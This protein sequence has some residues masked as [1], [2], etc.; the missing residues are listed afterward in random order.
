M[1]INPQGVSSRNLYPRLAKVERK[2]RQRVLRNREIKPAKKQWMICVETT[3]IEIP[4]WAVAKADKR[5]SQSE[6][7]V[8][9]RG[10]NGGHG[11]MLERQDRQA[12]GSPELTAV[13]YRVCKVCGRLMLS[14]DAELRRRLDE[15]ARLGR[16]LPCGS[17][18]K[19]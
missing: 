9:F 6:H 18:C 15:S 5:M 3:A 8:W 11:K 12:G 7:H 17:E 13:E 10:R 4:A 14:L 1:A 2:A 19:S 16:Q